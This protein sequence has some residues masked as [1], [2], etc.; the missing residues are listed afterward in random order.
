MITLP[1]NPQIIEEKGQNA[2]IEIKGLYPGYGVTLGNSLRRVLLSSLQ[3]AA[4]TSFKIQGIQHE[5]STQEYVLEDTLDIMLNLKKIRL[6][7]FSDEPQKLHIKVKGE[8]EITAR[9]IEK[10]SQVEIFNLDAHIATLTDK[11][12]EWEAELIVE[13]GIGYSPA[14]EHKEENMPIGFMVLDAIYSPVKKVNFFVE[15]MRVGKRVDFNKLTFDIET[16]G[17]T[18]PLEAFNE[19]VNILKTHFEL[20]SQWSTPIETKEK[21]TESEEWLVADKDN[22]DDDPKE[23]KVEEMKFSNRTEN[24][25]LKNSIK[26]LAGIL[27]YSE[28]GLGELEGLG[29]K[30]LKEVCA[31]VKKLGYTL[32]D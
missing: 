22:A 21:N 30:S 13:K 5:F 6:K 29:D 15:D 23:I 7:C 4:I 31:K 17:T 19:S 28:E 2:T 1:S 9:D 11:K 16:D 20:L 12:G 32:K 25:L 24:A 18:S 27:R 3:G 14:E 8:K 10:N 26:T